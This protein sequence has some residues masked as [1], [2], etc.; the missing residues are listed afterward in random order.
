MGSLLWG[1]K[2]KTR[3]K[4]DHGLRG[5]RVI[6]LMIIFIYFKFFNGWFANTFFRGFKTRKYSTKTANTTTL[7][8][9]HYM[10]RKRSLFED[11][12]HK[13]VKYKAKLKPLGGIR[14]CAIILQEESSVT[15]LSF[16][17]AV[18]CEFHHG[19]VALS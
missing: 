1:T 13:G 6:P 14:T 10:A 5:L 12:L 8:G 9:P 4:V 7:C 2:A 3:G 16:G 19:K 18:C 17:N 15:D 11:L